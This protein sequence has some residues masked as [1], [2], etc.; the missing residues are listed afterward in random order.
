MLNISLSIQR[1]VS[2]AL[3]YINAHP[4]L[5]DYFVSPRNV[6]FPSPVNS[7]LSTSSSV[8]VWCMT[9]TGFFVQSGGCCSC[10]VTTGSLS[11]LEVTGYCSVYM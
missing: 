8:P 3:L 1:I 7:L 2:A 6:S 9:S 4:L 5:K 11:S 10:L